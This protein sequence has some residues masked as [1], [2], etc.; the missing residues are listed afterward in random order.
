M[1]EDLIPSFGFCPLLFY[2]QGR[3][4]VRL[5]ERKVSGAKKDGDAATGTD[6]AEIDGE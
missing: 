4:Y 5:R 2:Y 3:A 1:V 6:V